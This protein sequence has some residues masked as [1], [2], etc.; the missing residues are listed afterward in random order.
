MKNIGWFVPHYA[1]YL[2]KQTIISG[3]IIS[4]AAAELSYMKSRFL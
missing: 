2:L 3:H 1:P 4:I